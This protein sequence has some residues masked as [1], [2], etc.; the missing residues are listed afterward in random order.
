MCLEAILGHQPTRPLRWRLHRPQCKLSAYVDT[1]ARA[2]KETQPSNV[3]FKLT[4]S[5][6]SRTGITLSVRLG[7]RITP[8]LHYNPLR[9]NDK[10]SRT[11]GME[12]FDFVSKCVTKKR[13][14]CRLCLKV[15]HS[16]S[17]SAVCG[18]SSATLRHGNDGG[19][20]VNG[21]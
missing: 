9:F 6:V 16:S 2:K 10:E 18:A 3:R 4:F 19:L 8:S 11:A 12:E 15:N 5:K 13:F 7:K 17:W 21:L 20:A 1:V 14:Y